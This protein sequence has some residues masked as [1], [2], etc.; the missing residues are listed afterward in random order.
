MIALE[1]VRRLHYNWRAGWTKVVS[2]DRNYLAPVD[3]NLAGC[4][5]MNH[6]GVVAERVSTRFR[7]VVNAGGHNSHSEIA[8]RSWLHVASDFRVSPHPRHTP[9]A[10][11]HRN[12]AHCAPSKPDSAGTSMVRC[13]CLITG[14]ATRAKVLSRQHQ[15]GS[16]LRAPV[17]NRRLGGL[18][19]T[20]AATAAAHDPT[21]DH[22]HVLDR[23][24]VVREYTADCIVGTRKVSNPNFD[25]QVLAHPTTNDGLDV[26]VVAS[27]NRGAVR[28]N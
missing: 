2:S 28:A 14:L 17:K 5:L 21:R 3:Q 19:A 23:W 8:S 12:C 20:S 9:A 18:H 26:S 13:S 11:F 10:R 27:D 7:I 16:A 6:G 24:R 15:D 22:R 1:C 25:L 4:D